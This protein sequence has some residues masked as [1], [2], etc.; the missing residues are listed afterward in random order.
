MNLCA[1]FKQITESVENISNAYEESFI[2]VHYETG[3]GPNKVINASE[4][5]VV[6]V[7]AGTVRSAE[8]VDSQKTR[9][10]QAGKSVKFVTGDNDI[11]VF[12]KVIKQVKHISSTLLIAEIIL[13]VR[14]LIGNVVVIVR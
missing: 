9:Y 11:G 13:A 5:D 8:L 4:V 14:T 6:T 3:D 1:A 7:F 2:K 12:E 10:I